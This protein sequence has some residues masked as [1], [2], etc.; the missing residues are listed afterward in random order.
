MISE[1]QA[2]TLLAASNLAYLPAGPSPGSGYQF[3]QAFPDTDTGFLALVYRNPDTKNCIVA[4]TGTQ[5]SFQ[6]AYSDLNL[7]WQQWSNNKIPL[8]QFLA[9]MKAD[10]ELGLEQVDFTG[11]S[12]GGALAQY[13]AYEYMLQENPASFTLTTF[14][15]FGGTQGILQNVGTYDSTRLAGI[16]VNH[17]RAAGDVVSR[18][19][20]G[21]VGGNVRVID[22]PTPDFIAAHRL[23]TSF[24]N[25]TNAGYQLT[26]LPFAT[27]NY[28]HVS[29]G[30]QLGAALGNLFND[31]TYNEFEAGLRTTGALLLVLQLAP[32]DEID[33]VMDAMVPQYAHVNWGTVRSL[34]PVSGGAV[35][36]GGAGL[37]LAA[38][39]YEGVQGTVEQLAEVKSF[40]GRI[41]G[42]NFDSLNTLPPRQAS[43]RLSL[44]LAATS[45]IG[46]ASSSLGQTLSGLTIDH[47]QLTTHLLS[48]TNWLTD[49]VNYLQAQANAA[50]QNVADFSARLAS[51]IDQEAHA[52]AEAATDFLINTTTV[53]ETFLRDTAH[54]IS[55]AVSEFLHDVPNTL[56]DLGRTLSFADLNPFTSAYASALDGSGTSS[57]LKAALEEAQSIVQRAGQ[58]VVIKEDVGLNPFDTPGFNPSTAPPVPITVTEG[59]SQT[60]TIYLPFAAHEGGQ[61]LELTLNGPQAQAFV[62]RT[63][64]GE[65]AL[66]NGGFKVV[67]PEGTRQLTV[68]LWAKEPVSSSSNLLLSAQLISA[69]KVAT[70][71]PDVEGS[72]ALSDVG[73]VPDGTLPVI[74]Y[75]NGQQSV[76]W[77]G[78]NDSNEPSFNAGANHVAFGNGGFDV[79]DFSRSVALFN[80]Q[81]YGGI[82]NDAL[83]G[84]E[85]KDRLFG[86]EGFDFL[87]GGGGQ[88]VLYGGDTGDR[89]LGDSSDP[90]L[91]NSVPGNDY[92]DGGLGDDRLEGQA[93]DDTL[94]GGV[95]ND[96]LFGDDHAIYVN[97]PVGRDYLDGGDGND[98]LFGGR[99]DD[100]LIGGSGNDLLRG[101]NK[102]NSDPDLI[103]S[104]VPGS[105]VLSATTANAFVAGDGGAD[106]LDGG[107]GDDTLLGDG[108]D[109]ILLGGAGNDRLYGDEELNLEAGTNVGND[110]LEGGA[111]NDE[112]FGDD[113]EDALF[114]GEGDDFLQGDYVNEAGFSDYLDGG[115][116]NDVLAGVGGEDVLIGGDGQDHL[117]G[118]DDE[119]VLDGGGDNDVL[120]G[121]FGNDVLDG[122]DGDD[123]LSGGEGDDEL[124]GGDGVDVLQG[125]DGE[126]LLT[127]GAGNDLL[128]GNTGDDTIFGEGG[129]DELQGDS[130]NDLLAGDAGDD[131]I[132]GQ[133]DDDDL[134][135][136]E[137][138]DT[139]WGGLGND[140]LDGGA[141]DDALVG[142]DTDLV[143][144]FGGADILTGG[145]GNDYLGGG[146][147][148]DTYL[149]NP[150]DGFDVIRDFAGEGNRLVFG[151]GISA[152]SL[153][154]AVSPNDSLVIRTGGS[155]DAV[156]IL[157][158]GTAN[159]DGSHP[160]DTFEFSDG[161]VLTYAQ[162]VVNG[163]GISGGFGA[164]MLS[165]TAGGERI[166]GG[167]G[168]D[169]ILG[170]DGADRLLGEDGVDRLDGGSGNDALSGGRG[171]DLLIGGAG[172]DT[173]TFRAGWGIDQIQD[174][175]G[176]GNR[177]I[178][179]TG[180]SSTNLT[181][182]FRQTTVSGGGGEEEAGGD[183]GTVVNYLVLRTGWIGDAVEIQWFDPANQLAFL[184]VDQFV[185]ADGT[186]L[187]SSQLLADG[188]ELVG[189]AGFDT[190][191]GR[192]IYRRIRGLAGDDVLIGGAIDNVLVGDDGRDV[193]IANGGDDQ[194]S[195]G[196]GDDV[197]RGG[198]GNDV[199]V[200][201]VGNDSLEGESGDDVL[202]GDIG[203]DQLNGGEGNDTYHFNL[204]DGFDSVFDSGSS[205]D[206]DT[207]TF[208]SGITS[209]S[210]SLSS[211]FGQ[212]VITVGAGADG[213][214]SGS[215]FDVFGSQ[216]IERFQFADGSTLAY[217]DL[218]ARGFAID[219]TEF[220]DVLFG[221]NLADRF[222]G[223]VGN[224]RLEGGEGNDSY[225]FNIGDGVDRIADT[226]SAG[227]GNE[228]V[229]GSGIT[230]SDLHLDLVADES[231][232]T[233]SDLLLRV[234]TNGD[235]I[236][237]DTF[238]RTN[239]SGPRTVETF[240]FADGS[241]LTYEQLLAHGFD[242]S[243]TDGDDHIDG[244]GTV[245]RIKAG[246]GADVLRGGMGDDQLDGE[247]GDD[248]LLGGQGNDTYLFGP[249]FG[250]DTIV[251]V[252]GSQDVI[253][254]A[255]GVAPSD[256]VVARQNNDL[257]LSLNGG[258][259]QL[260]V[261]LYFLAPPL[262]IEQIQFAD[263]TVWDAL[264]IQDR[265]RPTITGT[266]DHDTLVGTDGDDRLLGLSGDDHLA[267]L[268]GHDEL[269]GGSGAD[270]L[271]GGSGDDQ[272]LVEDPGD[273]I[274]E[275]MNDGVDTVRSSVTRALEA[276]VENLTL[277]GD[278]PI[279][280]MGNALDNVLTGN[281]AAN[282]LVGGL[283]NDAFV[284]GAGDTVIELAN[285]GTDTA[286]AH[287]STTLGDNLENLTLTG[288][289][290]LFGTGNSLDNVLQADGSIS[291]LAGGEGNDTYLI[292][293]NG[294][295]DILV[296][297]A[298]G[299]IDTVIAAH[300]YRL[301]A[302]IENLTLLDP[303]IPDFASFTL[304]PYSAR[305]QSVAGYGNDLENTLVGGRANNMLDGGLGADTMIG[306]AG[307][308]I[309]I[310][311]DVNDLV[312]EQSDEGIDTIHSS[313]SYTLG[314]NVEHLTLIGTASINA[315]G[316]ALNND[317]RGNEAP[318]V[319][320][321]GAGHDALIGFGG[322]D[323][324]LFGRGSG[325][326][327]V[328][329]SG[330]ADE[331]DTIQFGSTVAVDDVDVYRNGFNLELVI[332]G[333][334]DE[335]T[336][337]SF[338]G[339]AGYEQK[340]VRFA[341]G[342]LWDSA[343]LSARA[344]VGVTITGTFESET[345]V[346]ADG[347]DLLIG[348][349]GN[350][351]VQGGDGKDTLYG[352]TTFQS[353]FG[354]Q[355]IGDDT[356]LG[357]AGDD[358]LFDF[359]GNNLFDGGAGDDTLVLG[360]GIDTVLFG[361]GS[362]VDRVSLD[363]GRNDID[364]IH[365]AAD[366]A[367]ADVVMTW[368]SVSV[369]DIL[370]SDS[371]DR[372]TVQLSTDSFAV[373]PETTQA[374]V[375]FADGTE[376]SLAWSSFNV[377]V[378]A[379]TSSA[380]LLTAAFPSTLTGLGGDDIYLLGSSGVTGTYAVI[381][382][383]GEGID[384]I[385]SLFDYVLD[386][387]VENLILAEST[388]S[389]LSNAEFGTGNNLDN[390]L[391]GNSGDNILDGGTG[392][393]VLVGGLFRSIEDFFVL[394]TG[395]DILIGGA[396]D[397]VLMADGGD[398]V[399]TLDGSNE[400]WLFLDGEAEF[401]EGVPRLAD[402]LFIGG[403]GD[404]TYIL[405]GQEQTIAEFENEGTDT[406]K[407]TVSFVLGDHLENLM[408]VSPPVRFDDED[409]VIPPL[410]LD[411]TGNELD[412]VL[413]GSGDANVLSGLLGRDTLA[414]S[415]GSDTLRGGA[416]H[417]IYLFNIGDGLD[418]IVDVAATGEGNRIQF[419]M[420]ITQGDLR[421]AHDEGEQILTI[422]VGSNG[423]DQLV[424]TNFD[425]TGING[426]LVVETLAFADGSEVVLANLLGPRITVSGTDN[427]DVIGGTAG[428]DGIDAGSGDDTV[429]GNAGN[430]L[431][432]AGAGV[433]SVTG[434]E[435][436]DAIFGGTGTDYLYGGEG[437][438]AINGDEG[439]D[440]VVGDVGNDTLS[441]GAGNDVLNGGVGADQLSG[442]EGDDTLYID[443]AD[444]TVSGGV[445]YDAVTVVGTGAV[446]FNATT[447][448]VEFVAGSSGND[449]FT[450][451]GSVT[452]VTFYGGEGDDQLIGGDGNNV[453]VGQAGGDIL[454]GGLGHDVLNGGDGDDH[455]S[456]EVGDDTFYAGAGN[457]Q[458]TGGDGSDSVSGDDGADA[459]FG[460]DG[461]DY[462]YG[463]EGDDVIN[464]DEGNDVVVGD[465]GNDILSGGAGN[466]VLNGGAGADQLSGGEGDDTLYI[467]AA[468]IVVS[469][470]AGYDAV[471][472]LGTD[473]VI[474]NATTAE[475]EFVAGSSGNDVF[476]AVSGVTGVTFYGG[477]G[478]DRLT[479]SDGNDVLVG[480]AG[481]DT[482]SGGI[483]NDVLNGGDGD[484]HLSGELGNDTVY[485]GTGNDWISGGDGDDSVSGE[486]GVDTIL[487]GGGGDY[488]SGG[489]GDDV[490]S[491]DDG[492]DTL[493]GHTGN[494]TIAGG[495]GNDYLAGGSG[496]DVYVFSRGDEADTISEVDATAGNTDRLVFGTT[497][498]PLDLILSRQ[499]NDLRVAI[500]GTSDQVAIENWYLGDA[501]HVETIQAGNGQALLNT[502]V[503]QLIH[504]MAA[505]TEQTGL[506]WDQAVDQR[507]QDVQ[508]VLAASWQ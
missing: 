356:L 42:E 432:L 141:G 98:Y 457:D 156:E 385:Q 210:V 182:G 365:M 200:G 55:N 83:L 433:D 57:A 374:R 157:N 122:G 33:Q 381:E 72:V 37:I 234:G 301:P 348:S 349:A 359:R 324:Y 500:H 279:N 206:T 256:V 97:R 186:I 198:D 30:Q 132:F 428:D 159:P 488:L 351:V 12:L 484:D 175:A 21:H 419:G 473:A 296:E 1:I 203:D 265:L 384:T 130:G 474:F 396:G 326:D 68:H 376:W 482:L 377:G 427:N 69:T 485:G 140:L 126:D 318:N 177:L 31:G 479:G 238:D 478:D 61:H 248:R 397:D 15:A 369:A 445:G 315:T 422:Q 174:T 475:V 102:I 217:A 344:V 497:I 181:L 90:S 330:A 402:D 394:G 211:Q 472:V 105:M 447:A 4:F 14:N 220:D 150:G 459:I 454:A 34:L 486:D 9:A 137:G 501:H 368:R 337:L 354:P 228:V 470:G 321:G 444:T 309:Y 85:G 82:G 163:L 246:G 355:V 502:Q 242:L 491:G 201:E 29:T 375:R 406:V 423:A 247:S 438:D 86:E 224:D 114:G 320:D 493:V 492:N 319:L 273:L 263:G 59:Q 310:V 456:G 345:I 303:R 41:L 302:N 379:A 278:S 123:Q 112:L 60:L 79:L 146:G 173:Y 281:S 233:A 144:V 277:T 446:I 125:D 392:N 267:G 390:L 400:A 185:F 222:R 147:G 121:E 334:A 439:H 91:V 272:Y 124:D 5:P 229:F 372:L 80:H 119:D 506:T 129:D 117:A 361:R 420:G 283:G 268:A 58:T 155:G 19:G 169:T 269:D 508:A 205:A 366:I 465:A 252:Q 388:S 237:L 167:A 36:L 386:P 293:P 322:A 235:A 382:A 311:D 207:V 215:T 429:Y 10:P 110:W 412:N 262:Q 62:L 176:E 227:A 103:F 440:V 498:N 411:G 391:V 196:T 261:S 477:E 168:N 314:A 230:A 160:I 507:P 162:L 193:L 253:R 441:G 495:V 317:V 352:D 398:L 27:P 145:L 221:T 505:F 48:G 339:S 138:H 100:Q 99:G 56:F 23:E 287:V 225:F 282:L 417:D 254:M 367:P 297:T 415:G 178:F 241:A 32:A 218:V 16:D 371:G 250:R 346:G 403:M 458:V 153:I 158:Y 231:N 183:P 313:E 292:G 96:M 120:F 410:P 66:E 213:I 171:D 461:A 67:V 260:T 327:M 387:H 332:R 26:A 258:A 257:V 104:R 494:D 298:G 134:F 504:A 74:D 64:D 259:D 209:N 295:D 399:F 499:A 35:V 44:Y 172:L 460:G 195:G 249:G 350:D 450:A 143:S 466:D 88:D 7:G 94:Y 360:T 443:S 136:N 333:T 51:G 73:T 455:L 328:F 425:P 133:A 416:G 409:N 239:L 285:E 63:T 135:G 202:V 43:L 280:G 92:L 78:D 184:G 442:G 380:D 453:L 270:Q 116:G 364:V 431:I 219:G 39:V 363:G 107:D 54:G 192:D 2:Q 109:D 71:E 483:G 329:D 414:G 468:D 435:G 291:V 170:L 383:A 127:G 312:I 24:L 357:G 13:A 490:M 338:F 84:G 275:L 469:G 226:A 336:L 393:D 89:L 75:F 274:T 131:T 264:S 223:G 47:A 6:D 401:R 358:T 424:L 340:Q 408:L 190:L 418:T 251:E 11:H 449:V 8:F 179:G 245:D 373:G 65:L 316:N 503:D 347:H 353:L 487:G 166:F 188:L 464:G 151:A 436:A 284:V 343:E 463:G 244:T 288:S 451:V 480:Q 236:Q 289:A 197:L 154:V 40:L 187:T 49:S 20:E 93:G 404:D 471:T 335:L 70:H 149:F 106:Y 266:A 212:I 50:G 304:I 113:G 77:V 426:S 496:N 434:D 271:T 421:F 300:D 208:G 18:L 362:G 370:I 240:R 87:S 216:T 232:L 481:A 76:T 118:G 165:G 307:D 152:G 95:G 467:D 53:L 139:L 476:T 164:D 325:R 305:D 3:L 101:D 81:I 342:T 22:F 389:V 448:E 194:L 148:G 142:D 395:S 25:P 306:G 115:V 45:G 378:P 437:D 28:L 405:Y 214:L 128:L 430:D 191:D 46:L 17:F 161:T 413:F 108:G 180:I 407:S 331:I 111:G 38:G 489:D 199:L 52:L 341:D 294:D 286:Q 308:D 290:S 299:G 189:T 276:N 323:T 462:L 452:G 255:P 204:G 243:G